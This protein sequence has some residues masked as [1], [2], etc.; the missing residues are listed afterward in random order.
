MG[1]TV[2]QPTPHWWVL[3]LFPVHLH[4]P[5]YFFLIDIYIKHMN[6]FIITMQQ[7]SS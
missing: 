2:L 6:I 1:V 4:M 3:R 5:I 7:I